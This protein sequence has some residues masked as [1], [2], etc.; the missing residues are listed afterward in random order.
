MNNDYASGDKTHEVAA[1]AA[2]KPYKTPSFKFE[3]VFEVSAL[4]CGKIN[5]TQGGC[6]GLS[7]KTS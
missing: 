7:Q 3:S 5:T 1:S 4:M 2:K 6:S